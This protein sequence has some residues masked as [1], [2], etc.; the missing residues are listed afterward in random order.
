MMLWLVRSAR[1]WLPSRASRDNSLL[2]QPSDRGT[3]FPMLFLISLV[4]AIALWL[5]DANIA[6]TAAGIAGR[7]LRGAMSPV[8]TGLLMAAT[9]GVFY[10]L[11][12]R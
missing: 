12:H 10:Y 3:T 6:N 4:F 1:S 5:T 9:W 7:S 8:R 11:V 2:R